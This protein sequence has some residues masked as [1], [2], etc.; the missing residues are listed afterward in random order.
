MK[1]Y[2]A[3]DSVTLYLGDCR[4]STEWLAADVL[5]TD[6]P[7]GIAWT[8]LSAKYSRKHDG[9]AN[10]ATTEA[11][12]IVLTMWGADRPAIAFGSPI[13]APPMNTRQTL[14][15]R[16]PSETGFMG[17]IG[18]WRRDWE[19][20]YLVGDW[21]RSVAER[22]G[23]IE[24]KRGMSTYLDGSHPHAKP[25]DLMQYLILNSP[26]ATVAD[27]FAGSG[28]TLLAAKLQGRKAIGVEIE[29][30]YCEVIAKRLD[31]GVLDFGATA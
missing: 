9:I 2:Y 4:D 30:S 29:E 6:P 22:S 12:D 8:S 15:W 16:K 7:Y 28:S 20:I 14:V 26:G 11:R 21:K 18:G 3:D 17:A 13:I 1:P 23:V 10:D 5:I 31:Q 19:A 24:T 27:P 25:L